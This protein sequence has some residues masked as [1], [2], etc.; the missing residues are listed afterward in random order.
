MNH[1]LN[2]TFEAHEGAMLRLLGLIQRRGFA[3]EAISM[4]ACPGLEKTATLTL[5]PMGAGY[6]IEVLQRQIERLREI[7]DVRIVAAATAPQRKILN[8]FG[9]RPSP[10]VA[11]IAAHA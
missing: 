1:T 2:I 3:V 11:E 9:I 7:R 4:Q 5:S 8:F 6:R 10:R